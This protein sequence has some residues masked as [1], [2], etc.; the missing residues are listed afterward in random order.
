LFDII[1]FSAQFNPRVVRSE[2][3]Y[4]NILVLTY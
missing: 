2:A 4:L 3:N 1:S